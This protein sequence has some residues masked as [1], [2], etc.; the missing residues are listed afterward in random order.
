MSR[1]RFGRYRGGSVAGF[2]LIELLISLTILSLLVTVLYQ[3]FATATQVWSRQ[4]LFDEIKA[5]QIVARRLLEAD[6]SQIVSYHY[7]HPKGEY[8]FF[9]GTPTVLFYATKNGFGARN[10]DQ[11]GLF[12]V[13][14][15]LQREEDDSYSLR[16]YKTAFPEKKL[17]TVFEDFLHQGSIDQ[18]AWVVPT[19]LMRESLIV[20]DGLSKAT[21]YYEQLKNFT[22]PDIDVDESFT[23]KQIKTLL[24]FPEILRFSYQFQDKWNHQYVHLDP[25][26]DPIERIP[27]ANIKKNLPD[28]EHKPAGDKLSEK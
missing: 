8:S 6:L 9:V 1:G 13:C 17:L 4:E 7:R 26:P 5:R 22:P 3:A 15:F 25:F 20:I 24:E 10:R 21:F 14:C 2:T 19:E 23:V 18:N 16:I 12:F 28:G 11:Y 27:A